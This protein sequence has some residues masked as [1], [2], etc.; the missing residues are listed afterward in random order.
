MSGITFHEE[1][2]SDIIEE[3]PPLFEEHYNEVGAFG[4]LKVG[5]D[6][7]WR[8]YKILE[9]KEMLH[10]ITV[11]KGDKL[12][13][14]YVSIIAPHLHFAD[15]IVAENDTIF[16]SKKYRTGRIGIDLIKY[17]GKLLGGLCKVV[18]LNLPAGKAYTRLASR[19]GFTLIGNK[20]KLGGV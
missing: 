5:L 18:L 19:A 4:G 17:A 16:I 10:F 13:G 6:V 1:L 8:V 2:M 15:T 9:E 11:R 3:L 14:Y 20:F 12:V 7:Q